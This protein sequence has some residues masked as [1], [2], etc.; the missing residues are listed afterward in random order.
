[1][2]SAFSSRQR[3]RL[4]ASSD[5]ILRKRVFPKTAAVYDSQVRRF[6]QFCDAQGLERHFGYDQITLFN[7][8]Y[9]SGFDGLAKLRA[10]SI[11]CWSD[12]Y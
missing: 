10:H 4:Q 8:Y 5:R 1:M 12:L 9:V 2:P 3:A 11:D 6:F 7:A